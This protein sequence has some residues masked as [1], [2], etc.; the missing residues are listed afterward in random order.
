MG[1]KCH[2]HA[3]GQMQHR[4]RPIAAASQW[5]S[6]AD[7]E[8]L[9]TDAMRR[10]QHLMQQQQQ[11]RRLMRMQQQQQQQQQQE[12][13]EEELQQQ[14]LMQMQQ[15]APPSPQ[16]QQQQQQ[17]PWQPD[18]SADASPIVRSTD[19]ADAYGS[20]AS[21]RARQR[22]A[23]APTPTVGQAAGMHRSTPLL[24][25]PP[26]S[27]PNS[28]QPHYGSQAA[29]KARRKA[30]CSPPIDAYDTPPQRPLEPPPPQLPQPNEFG[31]QAAL[32]AR[33]KAA[34]APLALAHEAPPMPPPSRVFDPLPT[35]PAMPPG[36][37]WDENTPAYG[38]Q[39]ALRA[40]RAAARAPHITGPT[41]GR[42]LPTP[43]PMPPAV[44]LHGDHY[45]SQGELRARQAAARAPPRDVDCVAGMPSRPAE[46]DAELPFRQA[47]SWL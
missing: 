28:S 25:P 47:R 20:Q 40:R 44:P 27:S 16:K 39:A 15:Y 8:D 34:R 2:V 9:D 43:P 11:Q 24:P 14:Q 13:E 30:A 12:E 21:L 46:M 1:G 36:R 5:A 29:L 32:K 45:G 17:Q 6:P 7:F 4:F 31:T 42:P 18:L 26:A 10:E 33:Q 23:R 22:A 19:V 37:P 35:P 38:S 3:H 41:S